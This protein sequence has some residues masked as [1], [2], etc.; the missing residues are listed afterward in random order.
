MNHIKLVVGL[1]NPGKTYEH[2]PH[3]IGYGVIDVLKANPP[4]QKVKLEKS[5]GFMNSSGPSVLRWATYYH[6]EPSEVLIVCDDLD[7]PYGQPRIRLKGSSGGHKGLVSI[8]DAF[9]HQDIPRLRLGVGP[10]PASMEASEYVL[11]R[12]KE[13]LF[14]ATVERGA[15]AVRRAVDE[16]IE[17]AMNEFNKIIA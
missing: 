7:L 4:T 16:G 9:G 3:N 15:E 5:E 14:Q 10:V 17:K 2:T 1:G 12:T 6:C 8:F 13:E 11:R